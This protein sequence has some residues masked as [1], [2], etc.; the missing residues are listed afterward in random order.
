[1]YLVST[2]QM[3]NID[4]RAIE[5]CGV[6]GTVLMENAGKAVAQVIVDDFHPVHNKKILILCG[7][8]NNG[9]DGFVVARCLKRKKTQVTVLLLC[10][11]EEIKEDAFFHFKQLKKNKIKINLL[12]DFSDKKLDARNYDLIV[13]G[14]YGTGFKGKIQEEF[15]ALFERLNSSQI[16]IY[17]IDVPSGLNLDLAEPEGICLTAQKTIALGLAKLGHY[18]YPG[19]SYCG[20][21]MVKS[22]GLPEEAITQ[23]NIRTQILTEEWVRSRLPFRK[24]DTYKREMGK[25]F[26]AAGS[27]GMT[28]AAIL[29]AQ[30]VMRSGAGLVKVGI[31]ESVSAIFAASFPEALWQSLPETEAGTL[32]L[33]SLSWLKSAIEWCDI[34]VIGPGLST[35][36]ETQKLVREVVKICPKPMVIDADGINAFSG[37]QN[38]LEDIKV[39]FVLTPHQG[40]A[41]RLY[42]MTLSK[43]GKDRLMYVDGITAKLQQGT[44]VLKGNPSVIGN[45]KK[46]SFVNT[47]GNAGMATA[48]SGDVLTGLI[49]GLMAQGLDPF[50][51]ACCGVFIHGRAGDYCAMEKGIRG[52]MA[53]DFVENV[54]TVIKKLLENS[55]N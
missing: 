31:P 18:F 38:Q 25:V 51:A 29:V 13:D 9:G 10:L 17:S 34:F 15:K 8:G 4:R 7:K 1:M 43:T 22:I 52:L 14:V 37:K 5:K 45:I 2:D 30:A 3:R 32:S 55:N 44:L 27:R 48:G 47:T 40:E 36:L 49:A 39:N 35:H 23:E 41:Q 46:G 33:Q 24:P 26:V 50:K 54:P 28:G 19:R 16:P 53:R 11:E 21:V 20:N 6:A 12:R 42:P